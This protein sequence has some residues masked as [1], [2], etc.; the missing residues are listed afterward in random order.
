MDDS[1]RWK[2]L[3]ESQTKIEKERNKFV[4][5]FQNDGEKTTRIL[6]SL[7]TEDSPLGIIFTLII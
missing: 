5:V 4:E 1:I 7:Q 6:E 2:D 3:L